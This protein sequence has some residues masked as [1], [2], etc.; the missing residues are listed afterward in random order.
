MHTEA[1][2]Y[3]GPMN[4][5]AGL[6][7]PQLGLMAHERLVAGTSTHRRVCRPLDKPLIPLA[8]ADDEFDGDNDGDYNEPFVGGMADGGITATG[9][10]GNSITPDQVPLSIYS[11]IERAIYSA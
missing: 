10:T 4:A 7:D 5:F 1:T 11:S 3:T 9:H 2:D 8:G 6:I